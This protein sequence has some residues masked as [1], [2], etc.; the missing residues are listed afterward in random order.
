MTRTRALA[1]AAAVTTAL[2]FLPFHLA[3][4]GAV[5]VLAPVTEADGRLG[6]CEVL[7]GNPAGGAG[8][9]WAQLAYNAGA[10]LNRWE[11]RWDR[12]EQQQNVWDFTADDAAVQS[13]RQAGLDVLGIL[14]GT[15]DW[16]AAPGQKPGNGL[17]TGLNLKYTNT[18]NL[19][20]DYVRETVLH[21]AGQVRFWEVWN[22]PDLSYFWS[23][24]PDDYYRL[25]KV[26][27]LTI[28]DADP[29]A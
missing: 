29:Q 13:S 16:A 14:I 4:A 6:L 11:F 17:P 26:A 10:R 2:T 5:Q 7:A 24:S 9:S 18:D 21:Y 1:I 8:P 20:A 22:E 12:L 19:W 27:Y 15:P 23:G 3:L 28:K 25:L